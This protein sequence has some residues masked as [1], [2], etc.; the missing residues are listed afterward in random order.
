MVIALVN[1]KGGTGKTSSAVNLGS[2]LASLHKK[3]LVVDLDPQG[4]LTFSLGIHNTSQSLASLFL[5]EASAEEVMVSREEMDVIPADIRLADIE[6]SLSQSA[7]R[8]FF[9]RNILS[10]LPHYDHIL[11]DCPPSLSLLTI[12][13]L[14]A[15]NQVIIPLQMEVLSIK[16]LHQI[17]QTVE[18]VNLAFQHQ[19][20]ILGVL[21]VMIDSRKNLNGEVLSYIKQ[22]YP[23]NLF[24]THIRT[25]VKASEAP[26][27]G[28]SVI[29]YAPQ[30]NSA[31]DYM[32]LASEIVNLHHN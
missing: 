7:E 3:I 18:K 21:P 30:S 25:N 17:L 20:Q 4:S 5:N 1:Q 2:A 16:G 15:A 8:A 29:A 24:Q 31:R 22:H 10:N 12:N 26:S 6:I 11:I 14:T 13:A 23:V 28:K 19:L 9:L 27:F 32:A